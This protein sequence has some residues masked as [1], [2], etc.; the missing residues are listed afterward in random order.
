MPELLNQH[1]SISHCAIA[2]IPY[3]TLE[4]NNF[5]LVN[6]QLNINLMVKAVALLTLL[7]NCF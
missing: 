4:N 6:L 3:R 5:S 2:N 7:H 1:K